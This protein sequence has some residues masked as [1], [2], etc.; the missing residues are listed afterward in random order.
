MS[1][2]EGANKE[3]DG[4]ASTSGVRKIDKSKIIIRAIISLFMFLIMEKIFFD[5]WKFTVVGTREIQDQ[6]LTTISRQYTAGN[7]EFSNKENE[8]LET[9]IDNYFITNTFLLEEKLC[10]GGKYLPCD[11]KIALAKAFRRTLQAAV[12]NFGGC[13]NLYQGHM[14][15]TKSTGTQDETDKDKIIQRCPIF[16]HQFKLL[17]RQHTEISEVTGSNYTTKYIEKFE[18]V[19]RIIENNPSIGTFDTPERMQNNGGQSISE[20]LDIVK[21]W[22]M[23]IANHRADTDDET[24]KLIDDFRV[25]N[26]RIASYVHR[27]SSALE[28]QK[29]YMTQ[30]IDLHIV[31]GRALE[32]CLIL[33]I[34]FSEYIRE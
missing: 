34:I 17:E 5:D 29:Q 3:N 23:A 7:A 20:V 19:V 16:E 25:K 8:Q 31:L 26:G 24:R 11:K 10:I 18:E 33:F 4:D 28:Y 14:E 21:E 15:L 1:G 27:A 9:I 32:I 30:S 12:S 22:R 2:N 13:H 6:I